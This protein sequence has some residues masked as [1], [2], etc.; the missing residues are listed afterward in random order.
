MKTPGGRTI[1]H[2]KR[3]KPKRAKCGRCGARL[4]GV[5]RERPYRME[6]MAKSKKRPTRPYGGFLC[7]KCMR[8]LF[9]EKAR[10]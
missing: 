4:S 10:V 3:R 1:V 9:V 6:K 7:S 8:E 5:A 2:Y